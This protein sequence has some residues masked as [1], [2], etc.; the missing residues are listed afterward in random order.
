MTIDD[1]IKDEKL[2]YDINRKA[3][4][5]LAL[6]SG[7]IDKYEY[8]IGEETL[9][10]DESMIIRQAKFTY[11]PLGKAFEKQIKTIEE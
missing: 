3:A 10:S 8:L 11:S 1:K 6:S 5:I 2:Q 9:P 4:K 7:K